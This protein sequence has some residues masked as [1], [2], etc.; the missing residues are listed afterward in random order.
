M[1]SIG[2]YGNPMGMGMSMGMYGPTMANQFPAQINGK[3]K[4]R[5]AD[6]E[7]AFAQ[8]VAAQTQPETS[9]IQEVEDGATGL[10]ETLEKTQ[11][12]DKDA[13][14]TEFKRLQHLGN[15]TPLTI[16]LQ[17]SLGPAPKF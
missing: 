9:R 11:L 5:E 15:K 3:G 1:S 17:Q 4:S 13:S 10:E 12:D 6:F 16:L 7:A 8:I 2:Q 14:T